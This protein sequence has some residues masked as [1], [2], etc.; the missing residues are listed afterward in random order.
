[1]I[2]L[3]SLFS[4]FFSTQLEETI[5]LVKLIEATG[6]SAIGIHGRMREERPRHPN[7]SSAIKAA[8]AV[9]NIPVIAK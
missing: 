2:N 1:M 3:V 7:R 8:A 4:F 5:E 9:L 6:V